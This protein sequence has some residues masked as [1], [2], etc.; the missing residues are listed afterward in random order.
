VKVKINIDSL[1]L[2]GFGRDDS[3][4][5]TEGLQHELSRL[6]KENGFGHISNMHLIDAGIVSLDRSTKPDLAGKQTAR[7]IYRSIGKK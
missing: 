2:T 6:V 1:V 3:T 7:S 4:G 5:F